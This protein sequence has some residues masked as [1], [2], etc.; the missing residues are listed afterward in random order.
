MKG[1]VKKDFQKD[2]GLMIQRSF[3]NN[4]TGLVICGK[5]LKAIAVQ[6]SSRE[7]DCAK[8][9]IDPRHAD[10]QNLFDGP[11]TLGTQSTNHRVVNCRQICLEVPVCHQSKTEYL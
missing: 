7:E 6:E 4:E 10:L 2:K 11:L 3:V 5:T 8:K 9:A 1:D